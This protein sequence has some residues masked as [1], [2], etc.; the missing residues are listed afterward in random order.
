MAYGMSDRQ[1]AALDRWLT[2]PQDDD[3]DDYEEDCDDG[4][5]GKCKTCCEDAHQ[6]YL[7]DEGDRLYEEERDR[8]LG[9]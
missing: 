2:T 4:E 9:F 6:A 7:E 1:A 5:C 3:Y 8:R